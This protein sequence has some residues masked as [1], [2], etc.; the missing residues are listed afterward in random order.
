[1]KIMIYMMSTN[2]NNTNWVFIY[3]EDGW[4]EQQHGKENYIH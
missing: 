1:M 3:W 4:N 2:T